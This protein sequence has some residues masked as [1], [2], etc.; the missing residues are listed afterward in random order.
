V[1]QTANKGP[2][3]SLRGRPGQRQQERI[4]RRNRRQR[5]IRIALSIVSAIVLVAI[6]GVIIWQ[7]QRYNADQTALANQHGSATAKVVNGQ[8]TSIAQS[9]ASATSTIVN[10]QASA[11]AQIVNATGTAQSVS[12][13]ATAKV[14]AGTPTPV[15]PKP[16]SPATSPP[17]VSGTPVKLDSGL[18]YIDITEGQGM[19]AQSVYN[20][21]VYYTGWVQSTGKKFDSSYDQ[22]GS[23]FA[24][25]PAQG[26][27]PGWQEG[28]VGMKVGGTRRLII[29][30]ALAYGDQANGDIPANS[31]LIFDVTLV[32]LK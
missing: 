25:D 20:T 26:I 24:P 3:N 13:T 19:P 5:R 28:L 6:A 32:A 22:G 27:I 31:T 17:S 4:Q 16:T 14:Y 7:I 8:S 1:S 18:Q 21:S 2:Q 10:G 29:P 9:Q 23:T 15:V 12:I 11:T 30:P